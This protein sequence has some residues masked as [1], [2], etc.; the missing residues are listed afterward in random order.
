MNE[1][2]PP[3]WY[4]DPGQQFEARYWDGVSW[5]EHVTSGGAQGT[6]PLGGPGPAGGIGGAVATAT[7]APPV[8]TVLFDHVLSAGIRGRKH[9]VLGDR[10]FIWEAE[11]IPYDVVTSLKYATLDV[12]NVGVTTTTY[13]ANVGHPRGRTRI[14][15]LAKASNDE[16][17]AVFDLLVR[18]FDIHLV[19]GLVA[20]LR[21]RVVTGE[22]IEIG[23]VTLD[24]RGIHR[25]GVGRRKDLT[26]SEFRTAVER[27][28]GI[29]ISVDRDAPNGFLL[30][31]LLRECAAALP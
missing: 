11:L 5:T 25:K 23:A 1:P 6:A 14:L 7:P 10:A 19:P 16:V 15:F 22:T 8:G 29:G 13:E 20:R 31:V 21:D 28:E 3:G 27:D 30:P 26:W 4:P 9:L 18:T 17:R 12:T 2:V 24:R